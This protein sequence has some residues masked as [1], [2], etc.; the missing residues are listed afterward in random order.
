MKKIF[1]LATAAFLV[2]GV[3]FS[4][5]KGKGRKGKKACCQKGG[6]CCKDKA[7]SSTAKM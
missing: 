4:H 3:A 2:S 5:D 7:K 1:M 6:G